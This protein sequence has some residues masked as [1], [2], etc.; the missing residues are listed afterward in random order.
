MVY[1]HKKLRFIN[2]H[3]VTVILSSLEIKAPLS[4]IP[5]I[6]L[7]LFMNEIINKFLQ[8]GAKFIPEKPGFTYSTCGLFSK[9]NERLQ[10]N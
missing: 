6:C 10:M 8:V 2:E 1:L 5:I 3:V 9:N 4:Q 7:I